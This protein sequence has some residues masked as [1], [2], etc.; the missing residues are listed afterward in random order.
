MLFGVISYNGYFSS[1]SIRFTAKKL[2][3]LVDPHS[4]RVYMRTKLSQKGHAG[5][6]VSLGP[7]LLEQFNSY[8][9]IM[10]SLKG[11]TVHLKNFCVDDKKVQFFGD[12]L[13]CFSSQFI[14]SDELNISSIEEL[15][16]A[17]MSLILKFLESNSANLKTATSDTLSEKKHLLKEDEADNEDEDEILSCGSM[18]QESDYEDDEDVELEDDNVEEDDEEDDDVDDDDDEE[19]VDMGEDASMATQKKKSTSI[20]KKAKGKKS[21][22][23]Y[24]KLLEES[25]KTGEMIATIEA[26]S[27]PFS[28]DVSEQEQRNHVSENIW[29][30]AL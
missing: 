25:N 20:T 6:W 21:K 5:N 22:K 15:S 13:V 28:Y 30:L 2:V 29:L 24:I 7:F 17:K 19:S 14:R 8:F 1:L 23:Q 27:Y 26:Y 4:F 12:V 3:E 16:D 11:T 9:Y 10:G 18:N